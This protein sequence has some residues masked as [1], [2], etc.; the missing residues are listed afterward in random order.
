MKRLLSLCLVLSVIVIVPAISRAQRRPVASDL[1]RI[2]ESLRRAVTEAAPGWELSAVP[3]ASPPDSDPDFSG[4]S[5]MQWTL[6]EQRVR[7][8]I[9]QHGSR[10]EAARS[11]QQFVA[12]KKATGT[13][14][15]VSDAAYVYGLR[16]SI[17]FRKS[18]FTVYI[19]AV[20]NVPDEGAAQLTP[21]Q[22]AQLEHA[23]EMAVTRL[24]AQK[25]AAVIAAN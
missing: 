25:T 9:I 19:N 12:D 20:V 13:P 14:D 11:L 22:R 5:I 7:V 15:V 3:P 4:V 18:N 17:V 16:G 1:A 10:E 8:A 6:N 21:A 2:V 24:F 23:K